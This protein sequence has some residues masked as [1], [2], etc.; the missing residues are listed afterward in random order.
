M[1]TLVSLKGIALA[2]V[3]ALV[4]TGS[5]VGGGVALAASDDA[6]LNAGPGGTP[7]PFQQ[8]REQALENFYK[9][10]QL[11]VQ[12]QQLRIDL[13]NQIATAVDSWITTLKG[14]GKDTSALESALADFKSK[15]S[16]A[17][18]A[19]DQGA[20]ILSAHAG[21]DGDGKVT[22]P[23]Q[24]HNTLVQA[25]DHLVDARRGLTDAIHSLREAVRSFRQQ[26]R[27]TKNEGTQQPA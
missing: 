20:S 22:D 4:L 13:A 21:F 2:G 15:V 1:K 3:A 12:E 19:H 17:Q 25:R 11:A 27:P 8:V 26:N 18:S 24:A 16:A 10:A 6:L 14:Q 7:G 23:D 9:R 5:L